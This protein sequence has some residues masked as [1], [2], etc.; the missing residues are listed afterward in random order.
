MLLS[1]L[2][3]SEVINLLALT[4]KLYNQYK[5]DN[6]EKRLSADSFVSYLEDNGVYI[7]KKKLYQMIKQPP[8]D[9]FITN[10]KA[11]E[12]MWKGKEQESPNTS[13]DQNKKIVKSMAKKALK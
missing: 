1:E 6:F 13:D 2:E 9:N 7:D 10:I 4:Q 8:L 5:A 12:I 11:D 3:S